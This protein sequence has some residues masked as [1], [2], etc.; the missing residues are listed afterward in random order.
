MK[1][2][3]DCEIKHQSNTEIWFLDCDNLIKD[4]AKLIKKLNFQLIWY[5]RMKKKLIIKKLNF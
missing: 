2:I 4:E 1:K 3:Y 5:L